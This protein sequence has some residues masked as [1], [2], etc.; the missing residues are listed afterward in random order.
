MSPCLEPYRF[1]Y[2][3]SSILRDDLRCDAPDAP[4]HCPPAVYYFDLPVRL[5]LLRIAADSCSVPPIIP[6]VFTSDICRSAILT[7]GSN[8]LGSICTI[9]LASTHCATRSGPSYYCYLP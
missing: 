1:I 2:C 9:P 8:P 6:R 5:I 4:D 7:E 3:Y